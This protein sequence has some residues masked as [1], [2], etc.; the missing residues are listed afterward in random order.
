MKK[1]KRQKGFT[2]IESLVTIVVIALLMG[3]T[4]GFIVISYKTYGYTWHQSLAIGDAQRGID[5]MVREIREAQYGDDGSFPI[6]KAEDKEFIFYSDIDKDGATERVRYFLGTVGSSSQ[7]K[8][9]VTYSDGGSCV[10]NFS[11]FLTGTLTSAEITVSVEGDFGW[12]QEYADIY[13]DGSDEGAICRNGCS[14]CAANWEGDT[15]IDVTSDAADDNL[16]IELDSN[17][18][19]DGICDWIDPNHSMKVKVTLSWTEDLPSG[20]SEFKRGVTNPT[21]SP[22]QYPTDQEEISIISSYVR[23]SPPIF[24][25]YDD[26]GNQILSYPSRLID[27]KL[28][29][30]FL[31]IDVNPQTSPTSFE[32]ESSVQLR[33]LKND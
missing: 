18:R 16:Q 13:V 21:G 15:V 4:A 32:L 25:Y 2:L 5:I 28:I 7:V 14:D 6:E 19:V 10:V 24:K 29:K 9:C 3:A 8:E 11:N 30:L 22:I 1:E 33:N 12:S 27:T 26:D 17:Y 23:N 31:V 20:D